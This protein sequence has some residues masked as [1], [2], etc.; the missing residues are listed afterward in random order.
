MASNMLE[1]TCPHC[2]KTLTVPEQYLGQW[3]TCNHCKDRFRVTACL[4]EQ[5][6]VR[7]PESAEHDLMALQA[8]A[9]GSLF[10]SSWGNANLRRWRA[11]ISSVLWYDLVTGTNSRTLHYAASHG[12]LILMES[13]LANGADLNTVDGDGHTPLH[14]GIA[15]G[16][17][18]AVNFL[19]EKGANVN[20]NMPGKITA[21]HL[22]SQ[23]GNVDMVRL[24]L[25]NEA[26]INARTEDGYT[27][28]H[29]AS[30]M[31][32]VDAV[33]LLLNRNADV[34]VETAGGATALELARK[35][36]IVILPM[37]TTAFTAKD[38]AGKTAIVPEN[39]LVSCGACG[40]SVSKQAQTCPQCGHPL[41]PDEWA[42]VKIAANIISLPVILLFLMLLG[43]VIYVFLQ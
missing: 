26:D 29:F 14:K 22:A 1:V 38:V 6:G 28:L 42:L 39:K 5:R 11:L 25:D 40:K 16:Q 23:C 7:Y 9:K 36:G 18:R 10:P 30:Q 41:K 31:G 13:L 37:G 2:R 21:L 8:E 4:Q 43:L 34:S 19:I 17:L 35:S 33:S 15:S 12:D 20:A 3:G 32:C 27:P 24:L